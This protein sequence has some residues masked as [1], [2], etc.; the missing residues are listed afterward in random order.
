MKTE[1]VFDLRP[2]FFLRYHFSLDVSLFLT[3]YPDGETAVSL[4]VVI[5]V[6]VVTL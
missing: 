3:G 2:P 4:A 5:V 6:G 1:L